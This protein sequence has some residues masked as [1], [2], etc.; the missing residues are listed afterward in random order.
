MKTF[1]FD[2]DGVLVDLE[3]AL[4]SLADRLGLSLPPGPAKGLHIWRDLKYRR[5]MQY[6]SMSS[7]FWINLEPLPS[8]LQAFKTL[9]SEGNTTLICTC[10]FDA[11]CISQKITWCEHYL[12]IG[13]DDITVMR[14]KEL[15]AA[16]RRILID[17]KI[18]NCNAFDAAGGTSILVNQPWSPYE[19]FSNKPASGVIVADPNH[20]LEVLRQL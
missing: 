6:I 15:M 18:D 14:R 3:G 11:S 9:K 16:P 19:S 17:D 20:I 2:M 8:G 1:I 10:P 12:D 4:V 13:L 5:V 7:D